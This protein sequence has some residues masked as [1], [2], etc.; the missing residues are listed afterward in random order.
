M[1]ALR[2]CVCA[3]SGARRA[4]VPLRVV[5]LRGASPPRVSVASTRASP[6]AAEARRPR[7]LA[8][9]P[10][11]ECGRLSHGRS[12]RRFTR[13]RLPQLQV[14]RDW[15]CLER[16][17]RAFTRGLMTYGMMRGEKAKA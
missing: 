8:H 6:A 7:A 16:M 10:F 2:L 3:S 13:A 5:P 14:I 1:S 15:V 11:C 17:H 12:C 9:Q 4:R